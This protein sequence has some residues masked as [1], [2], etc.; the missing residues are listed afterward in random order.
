MV[1][2]AL[3]ARFGPSRPGQSTL[4]APPPAGSTWT[5]S[6]SSIEAKIEQSGCRPSARGR[7]TFSRRFSFA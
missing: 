6:C 1:A 4:S 3:S 7:P 5:S 2:M